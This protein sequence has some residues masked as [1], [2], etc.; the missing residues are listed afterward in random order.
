MDSDCVEH[1]ARN[2][3]STHSNCDDDV[4]GLFK[5]VLCIK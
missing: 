5:L 4:L 3:K 1:P 2:G